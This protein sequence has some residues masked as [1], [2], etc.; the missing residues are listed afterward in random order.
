MLKLAVADNLFHL[1]WQELLALLLPTLDHLF[2]EDRDHHLSGK[3]AVT[4]RVIC[5][6][7]ERLA[8]ILQRFILFWSARYK[9]TQGILIE[10]ATAFW[11]D[12]ANHLGHFGLTWIEI[13]STDNCA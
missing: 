9:R 13:E 1:S 6:Q 2:A 10:R 8:D 11:V 3:F 4:S 5:D 7:S 12:I